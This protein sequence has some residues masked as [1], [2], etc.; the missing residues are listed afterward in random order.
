MENLFKNKKFEQLLKNHCREILFFL[1]QRKVNFSIICKIDCVKFEPELPS[2]IA[3]NFGE[4][5]VFIL[6]GY[7]FESLEIDEHNLYFEA[8]FGSENLGSFVTAPLDCI[9]QIILPNQDNFPSDF[10]VYINLL[11]TY[12]SP[13]NKEDSEGITRSMKAL[14]SNYRNQRFKK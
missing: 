3:Q 14:L 10:C 12:A 8:G 6:A 5:T 4:L 13:N 11:A 2:E 1:I 9:V 7:T